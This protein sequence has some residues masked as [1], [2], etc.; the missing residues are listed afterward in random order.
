MCQWDKISFLEYKK[1][2][3]DWL[4]KDNI[5]C[6]PLCGKTSTKPG[7]IL[8]IKI[9]FGYTHPSK[10]HTAWNKGLTAKT[11]ERVKKYADTFKKRIKNGEIKFKKR[12]L[13]EEQKAKLSAYM[14]KAH[15][16][17]RA[18]NIGKSRWNN[19]PSYPEK[20][21]DKVLKNNVKDLNYIREHP[22]YIYSLD[23]AWPH[24]KKCIEIDGEQHFRFE[25]YQKRDK[26]KNQLLLENNWCI[27]RIRYKDFY[28]NTKE[29]ITKIINFIDHNDNEFLLEKYYKEIYQQ[30]EYEKQQKINKLYKEA[31]KINQIIDIVDFTQKNWCKKVSEILNI[32]KN[33]VNRWMCENLPTIYHGDKCYHHINYY[34]QK[35]KVYIRDVA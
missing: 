17:K 7:I 27:L 31:L 14:K 24:L 6:C 23:F 8:H 11:D 33:S 30:I 18:W 1:N 12:S 28:Y 25:E 22:F 9:H 15:E 13:T 3:N 2:V 34:N 26:C 35:N 4:V 20:F 32:T 19:E 5:Y 16:E 21:L 10:S 29:Y